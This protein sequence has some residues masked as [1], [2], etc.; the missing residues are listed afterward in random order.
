[1][2]HSI[3]KGLVEVLGEG[4]A[5]IVGQDADEH[6]RIILNMGA[7]IVLLG[8]ELANLGGG[9]GG[10]LGTGLCSLDDGREVEDFLALA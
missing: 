10:G 4:W 2:L 3:C 9:G 6:N 5:W 1:M 7:C 8:K